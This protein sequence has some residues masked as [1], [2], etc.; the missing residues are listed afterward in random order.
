[1]NI[2][3]IE[4][5]GTEYNVEDTEARNSVQTLSEGVTQSIN[6]INAVIPNTASASNMLALDKSI[7]V[8]VL[9]IT[10]RSGA[11]LTGSL[12]AE[13][14][15]DTFHNGQ[16]VE[17]LIGENLIISNSGWY[18]LSGTTANATNVQNTI[19]NI[20]TGAGET[21]KVIGVFRNNSYIDLLYVVAPPTSTVSENNAAPVTSGGVYGAIQNVKWKYSAVIGAGSPAQRLETGIYINRYGDCVFILVDTSETGSGVFCLARGY[22]LSA[23]VGSL[24]HGLDISFDS[25]YQVVIDVPANTANYGMRYSFVIL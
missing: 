6:S 7:K 24:S 13:S 9:Q 3:K 21:K 10:A 25:S 15:G 8:P 17:V 18:T 20:T 22:S 16:M 2:N 12:L 11:T 14:N 23:I 1:M 4:V 19:G 5:N